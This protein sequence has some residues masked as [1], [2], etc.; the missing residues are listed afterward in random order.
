MKEKSLI[1]EVS[2]DLVTVSR[3]AASESYD[4]A[5]LFIG[6][7]IRKYRRLNPELAL[8]LEQ[9]IKVVNT[10]GG[11]SILRRGVEDRSPVESSAPVDDDS[12]LSLIRVI[13]DTKDLIKPILSKSTEAEILSIIKER[14]KR[15][16]L[17]LHKIEPT[18]SVIM[19]GPPGVGKTMSARW[20]ASSLGK[21][22]WVLDLSAVMSSRLG[23]TGQNLKTVFEYA[24]EHE[25]VLLL[26]EIDAIAKRRG[27]E[28]DIGELKRLVNVIL[29]EVDHWPSTGLLLA[30]TNHAELIDPA[31]WRRFDVV[32]KFENPSSVAVENAVRRFLGSDVDTFAP[33]I[34]MMAGGLKDQSV[35]DIERAI[36]ALRKS[37]ILNSNS[38]E[39]LVGKIANVNVEEMSRSEK[40]SWAEGMVKMGYSYSQ[41]SK[42]IGI[43][44][45]TIRKH[46][47]PAKKI[48]NG[49]V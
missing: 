44:R 22:L 37:Y 27:D 30:A 45:D 5:R 15:E 19:V 43:S 16:L 32:L 49:D 34:K 2:C 7:L 25:A 36:N 40:L 47:G 28:S 46:F 26:D 42:Q 4:D 31:L 38:V 12:K 3:F 8:S 29:Q 18:R 20:I 21:A 9:S 24:K 33:W 17:A 6:R 14:E 35:S 39:Q 10:R 41:I 1:D 11:A 48:I 23:K 13:D